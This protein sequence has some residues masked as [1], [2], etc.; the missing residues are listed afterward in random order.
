MI[1]DDAP[2]LHWPPWDRIRYAMGLGLAQAALFAIVYGGAD[3]F[4]AQHRY[5]VPLHSKLD[6]AIPLVPAMAVF[7]LS[8]NLLLWLAPLV[9]RTRQQLRAIVA[10]Q[11]AATL[12][13]AIGFLALPGQDAFPL[14]ARSELGIWDGPMQ[15]ARWIALHHNYLPSLHVTY[16][17]I[18]IAAYRDWATG[19]VRMALWCWGAAII[20]STLLTHQH[21]LLDVAAGLLLGWA[22]IRFVYRPLTDVHAPAPPE[23]EK[24]PPTRSMHQAQRA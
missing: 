14:A 8:L 17:V 10:A 20:A 6:L 23:D 22:A 1:R 9:L 5:R 24:R 11:A 4:A 15:L 3:W 2:F 21:Y 12:V 18:C 13:A 19:R 16:T 7:Y